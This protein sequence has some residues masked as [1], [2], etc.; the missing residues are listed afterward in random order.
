MGTTVD[1]N[2]TF[3]L[4]SHFENTGY[5]FPV[6]GYYMFLLIT[7]DFLLAEPEQNVSTW[8]MDQGSYTF[9]LQSH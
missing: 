6:D 3:N 9:E 1:I 5:R 2:C 8:V 7:K 4:Q